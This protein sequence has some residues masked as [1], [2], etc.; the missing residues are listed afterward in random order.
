MAN[1]HAKGSDNYV[2]MIEEH[3]WQLGIWKQVYA[4]LHVNQNSSNSTSNNGSSGGSFLQNGTNTYGGS[5]YNRGSDP[6]NNTGGQQD[7]TRSID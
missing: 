5:S 6:Y 2:I 3:H 1:K 7:L 4:A